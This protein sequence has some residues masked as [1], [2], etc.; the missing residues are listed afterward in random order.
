MNSGNNGNSFHYIDK[1]VTLELDQDLCIGCGI[2]ELVCPHGVL[3]L[4]DGKAVFVARDSCM[5]CSACARNCPV[6]ALHVEAGEGCVRAI[7]NELL[8][9]DCDC[10]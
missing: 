7:I 9:R 6:G 2:C 5:D 1:V 10:C 3:A 4:T 8:G